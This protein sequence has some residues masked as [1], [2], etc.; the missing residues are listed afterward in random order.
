[1]S[2]E[3]DTLGVMTTALQRLE[4]PDQTIT[5]RRRDGDP[6][7]FPLVLLHGGAVDSRMWEPQLG[8]FPERTVLAPDARGHGGSSDAASP[9]RLT[10]DLVALL[11]ALDVERAVVVGLSMGGGTAVDT[12]LEH[13]DRVAGLVVSGTGSSA[14]HFT[15]PWVLEVMGRWQAAEH[16]GDLEGWIAAF[17]E[18]TVGPERR[19]E[20]VDPA[21]RSLVETMARETVAAHLRL[22]EHGVPVPPH[23]P[24]PVEDPVTRR[25]RIT[26]PVLALC[27]A[28][29]G[30]DHRRMG[31]ELAA[32]VPHGSWVETPG[33]H[34]PNL[35]DPAA[36]DAAVRSWLEE[37]GL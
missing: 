14:P 26:V 7:R 32:A 28:D 5:Y 10:D 9:Y 21:V 29:D 13:P 16:G 36:F 2:R 15:D 24:T 17:S 20:Q 18:F 27:G 12:A 3:S 11:D 4:L 34:Y 30:A 37:R 31:R 1:M 35:E 25:G 8:A 22:D 33:A 19:P 23:P 6:D